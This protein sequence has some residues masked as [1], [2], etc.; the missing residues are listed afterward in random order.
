MD[1]SVINLY[2]LYILFFSSKYSFFLSLIFFSNS[3]LNLSI[4]NIYFRLLLFY[5]NNDYINN[6]IVKIKLKDKYSDIINIINNRNE[7]GNQ[8]IEDLKNEIN[9]LRNEVSIIYY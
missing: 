1:F 8:K 5:I 7:R 4:S 2:L 6:N 9:K 3:F